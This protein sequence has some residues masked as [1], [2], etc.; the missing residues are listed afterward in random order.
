MDSQTN[1]LAV[2]GDMRQI[3]AAEHLAQNSCR[4][5]LCG[6]EGY[7]VRGVEKTGTDKLREAVEACEIIVLPLP[8]TRDGKTLVSVD[9][10]GIPINRL[11]PML[12]ERH[13]VFGG[14]MSGHFRSAL[15]ERGCAAMD[16]FNREDVTIANA[17]PTAQ[18]VLKIIL[19]N[20]EYTL[21][22]AQAAVTG[23]G[24]TAKIIAEYLLALG[25]RVTVC[26]RKSG[27]RALASVFGCEVLPIERLAVEAKRFD[28]IINTVP[29]RVIDRETINEMKET[30]LIIDVASAPFGTDFSAA[31][32]R[33][34]KAIQPGSLPGKTA[35]ISAG[36]II[37]DA[38]LSALRGENDE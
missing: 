5:I 12:N 30:A 35:P 16:Y 4:V 18:G 36:V 32:E 20:I 11:L 7:D 22:G 14:M 2:G 34:I 15:A 8:V 10:N 19:N 28:I 6:F 23:Y 38:I 3:Y 13:T 37:A 25:A 21:F 24:R 26:A 1:I 17:V 33:G 31:H 9:N 29:A 27:S